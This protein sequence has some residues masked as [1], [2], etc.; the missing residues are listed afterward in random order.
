M[1]GGERLTCVAVTICQLRH[2]TL[3]SPLLVSRSLLERVNAFLRP[4][5]LL[6]WNEEVP[7]AGAGGDHPRPANGDTLPAPPELMAVR[8][9]RAPRSAGWRRDPC[10]GRFKCLLLQCLTVTARPVA[11]R[12][13]TCH[14]CVLVLLHGML[15]PCKTLQLRSS[16]RVLCPITGM[17]TGSDRV[18]AHGGT[19]SG[20]DCN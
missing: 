5:V 19:V 6:A 15:I 17:P 3:A 14:L 9:R 16:T 1:E 11:C 10:R 13:R 18:G 12:G 4:F 20:Q 7:E 2:L 8:V